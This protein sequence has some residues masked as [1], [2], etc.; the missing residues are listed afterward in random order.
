MIVEGRVLLRIEHLEQRRRRIAAEIHR[1]LV[2]L[3]EQ[4]QR[5]SHFGLGEILDDLAGHRADIGAAVTADLGFVA[6]AAQRHA[7]EL[8]IGGTRDA[9]PERGLADAR[10]SDETQDRALQ[11]LHALLHG[12]VLQDA[13]L[14][15]LEAVVI[16]LEHLFGAVQ[17]TQNLAALLPRRFQE[18]VDVVAHDCRLGR[19]R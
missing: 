6:H 7:H 14:D 13:F 16:L 11:A 5:I 2:D 12:E 8:A 10:W 4:E 15:L 3:V 18:P 19:H 17:V 1:H 9:L